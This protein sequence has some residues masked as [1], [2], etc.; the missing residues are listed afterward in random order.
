MTS[1]YTYAVASIVNTFKDP[2]EQ[3]TD[4]WFYYVFITV[5]PA[6]SGAPTFVVT[7]LSTK[8]SAR[9]ATGPLP[10]KVPFE[11]KP[12]PLAPGADE[13]DRPRAA[14]VLQ[15][16]PTPGALIRVEVTMPGL[17]TRPPDDF[18]F[19]P[20]LNADKSALVLRPAKPPRL[21]L[22]L[23]TTFVEKPKATGNFAK[24]G[25]AE[26][27]A[28]LAHIHNRLLDGPSAAWLGNDG[29]PGFLI[30]T[31]TQKPEEEEWARLLT[32][33]M[34]GAAYGLPS[35]FY[36]STDNGMY[37]KY[38]DEDDPALPIVF[39]CQHLVTFA[40]LTRGIHHYTKDADE[41]FDRELAMFTAGDASA[42]TVKALGGKYVLAKDIPNVG[43]AIDLGAT[44]GSSWV[45]NGLDEN[46]NEH[47]NTG[48]AHI[49]FAVRVDAA[50][51][52]VQTI[53]TGGLNVVGRDTP[54][55]PMTSDD[56]WVNGTE[57][58]PGPNPLFKGVCMLPPPPD[59]PGA[60]AYLRKA[61]P[62]GF[63]RLLLVP[64]SAAAQ[65]TQSD[66]IFVSKLLRLHYDG[67]NSPSRLTNAAFLWSLREHPGAQ[68]IAATWLFYTPL[69]ELS[70]AMVRGANS[71]ELVKQKQAR[72]KAKAEKT[73]PPPKPP[74][75]RTFT[76]AQLV[77][78]AQSTTPPGQAL[79]GLLNPTGDFQ[80]NADGT[81]VVSRRFNQFKQR[82][83][84]E[85]RKFDSWP[86]GVHG[87]A[88]TLTDADLADLP[89]FRDG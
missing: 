77:A 57:N 84:P 36:S 38:L 6:A 74:S 75:P 45:Y 9:P 4:L 2:P 41:L 30:A 34:I 66:A 40:A 86:W 44:P 43:A 76:V 8:K 88:V 53:D 3:G 56:P 68:D 55:Q 54:L 61:R 47:G 32:E 71:A 65:P 33:H 5:D 17:A 37:L 83:L 19:T 67:P 42:S 39:E 81:V 82:M 29:A 7:E 46:G 16:K 51:R 10:D 89:Y 15:A 28:I 21:S 12:Y 59:L 20:K 72:A 27:K 62:L 80:S 63:A 1:T 60:V 58:I 69:G 35:T 23:N 49:G 78:I 26:I 70:K 85:A 73:A 24:P 31:D 79:A 11:I 22:A 14:L 25:V 13:A 48:A 64:R 52:R 50:G 18:D 87:G